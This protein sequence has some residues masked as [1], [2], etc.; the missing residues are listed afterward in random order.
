VRWL[1]R[2]FSVDQNPG[3]ATPA[4]CKQG[5]YYYRL[6]MA[7]TLALL[8]E[9]AFKDEQGHV[10]DWRTPLVRRL[11]DSQRVDGSWI[12]TESLRWWEGAPPLASAYA[13]LALR[14]AQR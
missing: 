2:N 10:I 1:S 3:F 9:G 5:L 7:R 11:L 8:P 13:L 12:N 6:V 4:E 14:A